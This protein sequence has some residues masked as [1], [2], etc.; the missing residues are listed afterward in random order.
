ME[1]KFRITEKEETKMD[2][3]MAR[4]EVE[5]HRL[6]DKLKQ[7][8]PGTDEYNAVQAELLKA[9]EVMNEVD[10]TEDARRG[11]KTDTAVRI[12]TFAA[13]LVLTPVITTVCQRNLAKFIGTIEQ[14]ETFTSMPGRSIASW[15]RWK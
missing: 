14:M 12:V 4:Y 8:E 15:F 6:Q 1:R 11:A 7:L 9:I 3:V 10:K 5:L 13:G 2:G